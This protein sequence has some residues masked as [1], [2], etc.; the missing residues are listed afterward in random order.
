MKNQRKLKYSELTPN[1]N[2]LDIALKTPAENLIKRL[3][4]FSAL[5]LEVWTLR[6]DLT[7]VLSTSRSRC[8]FISAD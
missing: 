5:P 7:P 2:S 4:I 8:F 6:L 1:V 3:V